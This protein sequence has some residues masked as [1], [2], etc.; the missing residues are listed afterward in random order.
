MP[1]YSYFDHNWIIF[2]RGDN[3]IQEQIQEMYGVVY[4][5]GCGTRP[6][7]KAILE[8]A[9]RY[10]GIDWSNTL[11]GLHADIVADLC[12]PL[13]IDSGVADVVVSFQ[14]MEHLPEPENML[15]EAFRIL[16]NGGRILLTVPFQWW[17]HE[18]PW[19]YYRYTRYGLE[20]M[21]NRVGFVDVHIKETSGFWIMWVLKFNYQTKRYTQR[22]NRLK[23]VLARIFLTPIWFLGQVAAP[24]LDRIDF[25]P[26]ETSGYIVTARK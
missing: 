17:I 5:L 26:A 23:R 16:R 2:R 12:Q 24:I 4:D 19:D 18:A 25:N 10:I 21:F 9:D 22:G 11:H 15:E 20:Y 13:P 1:R 7:E 6:Y 8:K 14:V 3:R